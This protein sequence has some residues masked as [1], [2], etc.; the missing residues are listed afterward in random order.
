MVEGDLTGPELGPRVAFDPRSGGIDPIRGH[1]DARRGVTAS[2]C[3]QQNQLLVL[4]PTDPRV[5]LSPV[6][7]QTPNIRPEQTAAVRNEG[8]E[9]ARRGA[10]TSVTDGVGK[11]TK[12]E[13]IRN[14]PAS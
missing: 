2:S 11:Q 13:R 5:S 9:S 14:E 4:R 6:A 10:Q 3:S 7:I 8:E 12:P 1:G